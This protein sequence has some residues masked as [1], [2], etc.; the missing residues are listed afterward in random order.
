MLQLAPYN[1]SSSTSRRRSGNAAVHETEA[2]LFYV[3][4]G[5]ATLVTGGTLNRGNPHR[6]QS[7]G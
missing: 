4:D 7:H 3:V 5:S 2:E 1:V 6:R